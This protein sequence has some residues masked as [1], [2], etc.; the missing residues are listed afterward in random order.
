MKPADALTPALFQRSLPFNARLARTFRL[1]LVTEP[2][3]TEDADQGRV[4]FQASRFPFHSP[5]SHHQKIILPFN[6]LHEHQ[7]AKQ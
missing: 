3:F 6:S 1:T 5:L 4:L 2:S 7:R